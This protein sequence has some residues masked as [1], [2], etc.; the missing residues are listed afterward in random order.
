MKQKDFVK[1]SKD[2]WI[3]IA[4]ISILAVILISMLPK[5]MNSGWFTGLIPPLQY[6]SYNLGFILLT[7][8]L[9][10]TPVSWVLKQKI[11]I[12]TMLKGGIGSWLIFSFI[13]DMWQPPFAFSTNGIILIPSSESL[14]GTSVDYMVGWVYMK[15]FPFQEIIM[16]IPGIGK[17]SFLFIL[18]YFITPIITV[19]IA[20]L[21][22][23]PKVFIKLLRD[24]I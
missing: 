14:V 24:R 17:I 11:H 10:G 12:W 9:L 8:V 23:K 15:I 18:V 6:F 1:I 22:F 13:L 7:I 19:F 3:I 5:M 16:T 20:A 4:S 21:L 2:E